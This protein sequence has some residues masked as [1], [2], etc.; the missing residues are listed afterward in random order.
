MCCGPYRWRS[1]R[2]LPSRLLIG[3]PEAIRTK[4][5]ELGLR[6]TEGRDYQVVSVDDEARLGDLAEDYY[7]LRR[8]QGLTRDT[9]L[10][11]MRRNKH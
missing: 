4:I 10:V 3:R 1:R 6:L 7:R 5:R 2:G 8:R 11:D 9:A